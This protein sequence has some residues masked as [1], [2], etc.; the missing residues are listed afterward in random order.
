MIGR[1]VVDVFIYVN[2]IRDQFFLVCN[3]KFKKHLF[4]FYPASSTNVALVS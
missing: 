4:C 1:H 3:Y 2:Y